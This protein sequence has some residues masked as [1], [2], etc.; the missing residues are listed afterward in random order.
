MHAEREEKRI[1]L[2]Q[3]VSTSKVGVRASAVVVVPMT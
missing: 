2:L 3:R 1:V